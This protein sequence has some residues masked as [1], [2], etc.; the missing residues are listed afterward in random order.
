MTSPFKMYRRINEEVFSLHPDV[1]IKI[2]VQ[3]NQPIESK[4]GETYISELHNEFITQQG[5]ITTNIKYAYYL[6][7]S[8]KRFYSYGISLTWD[9]YPDFIDF[10]NEIVDLTDETKETSPFETIYNEFGEVVKIKCDSSICKTIKVED[11][12]GNSLTATPIVCSYRN[13]TVT[14]YGVRLMFG[15]QIDLSYDIPIKRF[16]GLKYFLQTY[17]PLNHASNMINYLVTTPL[18]GTNRKKI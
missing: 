8:P 11:R 3:L 5:T 9:V 12:F 13:D 7:L 2:S 18:L 1:T 4:T 10:V 14:E 6:S 17:N 15:Q 16:K